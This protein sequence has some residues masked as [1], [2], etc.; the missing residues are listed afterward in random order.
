MSSLFSHPAGHTKDI[1]L[2]DD[3]LCPGTTLYVK[4]RLSANTSNII[5]FKSLSVGW[6]RI[7]LNTVLQE[8]PLTINNMPLIAQIPH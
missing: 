3:S 1:E 2:R 5:L 7:A 8:C 4:G 6:Y